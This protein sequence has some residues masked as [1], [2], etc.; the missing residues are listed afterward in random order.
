MK[1][2]LIISALGITLLSCGGDKLSSGTEKTS[3]N[4]KSNSTNDT[5]KKSVVI[6]T[7]TWM[8][9]NLNVDKFKNGDPIPEAKS[10]EEWTKAGKEGKP[11]WCYYDNDPKNGEKYGKLY[12]WY[13]VNDPRGLAPAGWH[14]PSNDD[15]MTLTNTLGGDETMYAEKLKSKE[16]WKAKSNGESGNGSNSSGFSGNPGGMR[17]ADGHFENVETAGYWWS[18]SE[19]SAEEAGCRIL[20]NVGGLLDTYNF[21]KD[22]GVAARCIKD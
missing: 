19:E 11:A 14:I 4:E 17:F 3:S 8:T 9:E 13:A 12:N 7:Q 22:R 18:S 10:V 15:W 5:Q 1:S 6:G 2:L 16:G 20:K 21:T